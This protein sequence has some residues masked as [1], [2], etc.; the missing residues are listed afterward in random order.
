VSAL[1]RLH[2]VTNDDV[3]ARSS[4]PELAGALLARGRNSVVMH[5]RGHQ[6]P[7]RLLHDHAAIL[8][9]RARETGAVLIVNDRIDVAL[10]VAADGVQL[11]VR[12][13]SIA[14]ARKLGQWRWVGYSAHD[15][16]EAARVAADGTD[17]VLLG[18]IY[19]TATH[20]HAAPGGIGQVRAA[21]ARA[22]VP[23]LAIGGVTPERIPEL[24]QVGAYGAAVMGGIWNALDPVARTADYLEALAVYTGPAE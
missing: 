13:L 1:P 24:V 22:N 14:E 3:L 10:A 21:A 16:E 2:I 11:N 6:T 7:T 19:A 18:T 23:I 20:P 12:S 15:P 17:F 9:R 5:L 4:F 8:R